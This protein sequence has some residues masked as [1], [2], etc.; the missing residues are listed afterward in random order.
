MERNVIK[1][2]IEEQK[3]K[4][5]LTHIIEIDPITNFHIW[6]LNSLGNNIQTITCRTKESS[7]LLWCITWNFFECN[8]SWFLEIP[9]S[10]V[11]ST[12]C[13]FSNI[14][15]YFSFGWN[16]F[17]CTIFMFDSLKNLSKVIAEDSYLSFIV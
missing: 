3:R 1:S 4:K 6:K 15:L 17:N 7:Q 11:K 5:N 10:I 16:N 9:N 2:R 12:I 13:S 8:W 14:V